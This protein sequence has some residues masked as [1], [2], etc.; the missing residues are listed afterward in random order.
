MRSGLHHRPVG[1]NK[2]PAPRETGEPART[3]INVVSDYVA[4]TPLLSLVQQGK[5]PQTHNLARIRLDLSCLLEWMPIR[6]I[7]AVL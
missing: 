5:T 6:W 1:A 3:A 2:K 7:T 4:P